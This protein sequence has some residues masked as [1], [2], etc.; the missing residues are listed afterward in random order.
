MTFLKQNL[1]KIFFGTLLLGVV[2]VVVVAVNSD[3][4]S[5]NESK[6]EQNVPANTDSRP[7]QTETSQVNNQVA[8]GTYLVTKVVDGDTIEIEGGKTIRYIGID[9]PETVDP[10]KPVQCFGLEA[11]NKNKEL[12]LNKR[13]RLE[14]DVSETD[15]YGRLLRYVY[16]GD[17]FVNDYLVR[18]GYAYAS[19]YPPDV[20]YQNQFTQAQAEARNA[21]RGLWGSCA[22]ATVT[23]AAQTSAPSSGNYT[24]PSCASA[25]CNCTDFSTHAYARWFFD[26]Y[27]PTNK[28]KLDGDG[29]GIVCENLP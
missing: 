19:S 20:K 28:H 7:V 13:V 22:S 23:P 16:V 6:I 2:I 27:D 29:D 14:K 18:Q 17:T 12:V 5:Q 8:G 15:K 4:S 10:R 26:N 11:S 3:S 1:I 25:D 24:I 21:N 9:T